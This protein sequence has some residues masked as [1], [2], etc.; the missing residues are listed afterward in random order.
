M[1]KTIQKQNKK[2]QLLNDLVRMYENVIEDYSNFKGISKDEAIKEFKSMVEEYFLYDD[3]TANKYNDVEELND[4]LIEYITD[5]NERYLSVD[6]EEIN[7]KEDYIKISLLT[8][9]G[10]P[11][12][13]IELIL[14]LNNGNLWFD[15]ENLNYEYEW[16]KGINR[17]KRMIDTINIFDYILISE[18]GDY[19]KELLYYIV[20]DEIKDVLENI[21]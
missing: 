7:L 17:T 1:E 10:G 4:E 6:I 8:A 11:T 9:F 21:C 3:E 13:W 5:L 16:Y 14:N 12:E 18:F 20:D 15:E 19:L 2:E